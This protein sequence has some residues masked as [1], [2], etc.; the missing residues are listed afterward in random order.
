MIF[1]GR[2][3]WYQAGMTVHFLYQLSAIVK[4]INRLEM[5]AK[6]CSDRILMTRARKSEDG[7]GVVDRNDSLLTR[8]K[9]VGHLLSEVTR[10]LPSE[11][12][13]L[14]SIKFYIRKRNTTILVNDQLD[15]LFLNVFHD[16]TCFEQ[17]VL[18]IRRA[19]LY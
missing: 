15:A 16:S 17:Q 9:K 2:E 5:F 7:G 4:M 19:K 1:F 11:I 3:T 13:L 12:W 18:I 14:W 10:K 8:R 6:L